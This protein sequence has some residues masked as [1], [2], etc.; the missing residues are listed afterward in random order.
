MLKKLSDIAKKVLRFEKR[1]GQITIT[2][3]DD[4]VIRKLNA[5]YRKVDRA[6]DV[7]SFEMDEDGI[8]G[9]IV[10]SQNTALRNSKRF[11]TKY[12]DEL[13][14]LVIHGALHLIGYDHILKSDRILMRSKED[15]YAK[16]IC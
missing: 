2:L 5:Q 10:I 8:L 14:R 1:S 12:E 9:D 13:K 6:T 11:K 3:T 16:K 15:L 7:L 4:K